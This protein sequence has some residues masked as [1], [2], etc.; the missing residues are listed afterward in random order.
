MDLLLWVSEG[1]KTLPAGLFGVYRESHEYLIFGDFLYQRINAQNRE[2]FISARNSFRL[3]LILQNEAL[4]L[5]RNVFS[6]LQKGDEFPI[7]SRALRGYVLMLCPIHFGIF[8]SQNPDSFPSH[9]FSNR[10][11]HLL[12]FLHFVKAEKNRVFEIG[13]N[14]VYFFNLLNLPYIASLGEI[15]E[16]FPKSGEVMPDG[17]HKDLNLL[18][19]ALEHQIVYDSLHALQ[20][21]C[22]VS[23]PIQL[24]FELF[25][26]RGFLLLFLERLD[27]KVPFLLCFCPK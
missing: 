16:L 4:L 13:A 17:A 23:D 14:L 10:D 9:C 12:L 5:D 6:V 22:P 3:L 24:A 27:P 8:A 15:I 20:A 11:D 19:V 2:N 18:H 21:D 25:F 26:F 1:G 7:D